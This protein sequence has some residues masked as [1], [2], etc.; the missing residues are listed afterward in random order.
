MTDPPAP[1]RAVKTTTSMVL[2]CCRRR[3]GERSDNKLNREQTM[4]ANIATC[5]DIYVCLL[6]LLVLLW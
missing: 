5:G 3:S 2:V 1:D 4:A 6:I